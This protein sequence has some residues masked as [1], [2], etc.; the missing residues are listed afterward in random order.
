M[1]TPYRPANIVDVTGRTNCRLSPSHAHPKNYPCRFT[2]LSHTLLE[3][4]RKVMA[5]IARVNGRPQHQAKPL[6][7]TALAAVPGWPG[8]APGVGGKSFL[9]SP[10]GPGI[11]S[12]PPGRTTQKVGSCSDDL[13][14]HCIPRRQR[15]PDHPASVQD[16]PGGRGHGTLRRPGSG[17][18]PCW[19]SGPPRSCWTAMQ[20]SS[21]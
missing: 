16:G 11:A 13:V 2:P 15:R 3:G 9:E 12:H 18:K 6:T 1:I 10:G 8:E 19:P 7:E 21:G 5:G 17:P 14:G 20:K 4:V